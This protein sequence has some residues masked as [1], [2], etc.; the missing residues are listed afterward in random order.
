MKYTINFGAVKEYNDMFGNCQQLDCPNVDLP[1]PTYRRCGCL[2]TV[3]EHITPDDVVIFEGV[4][5]HFVQI[6]FTLHQ[7]F[8]LTG[9]WGSFTKQELVNLMQRDIKEV[10]DEN[11]QLFSREFIDEF[12]AKIDQFLVVFCTKN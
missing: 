10:F 4:A 1:N 12:P 8:A 5:N 11:D 2:W 3:Y 9:E 7:H 6:L